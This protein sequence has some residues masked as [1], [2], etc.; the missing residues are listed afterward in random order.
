[1]L[2]EGFCGSSSCSWYRYGFLFLAALRECFR[3]WLQVALHIPAGIYVPRSGLGMQRS[4]SA[5]VMCRT[6]PQSATES[7]NWLPLPGSL[8]GHHDTSSARPAMMKF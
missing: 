2:Y 1:M 8:L 3:Q 7:I 6:L 4:L 5:M